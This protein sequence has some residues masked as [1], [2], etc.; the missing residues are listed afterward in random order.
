MA[1]TARSTSGSWRRLQHTDGTSDP[2]I[3]S[4]RRDGVAAVDPSATGV[5]ARRQ[6]TATATAAAATGNFIQASWTAVTNGSSDF[7]VVAQ[8]TAEDFGTSPVWVVL[9]TDPATIPSTSRSAVSVEIGDDYTVEASLATPSGTGSVG[10]VTAAD[11]RK[12]ISIAVESLQG[13]VVAPT[14]DDEGNLWK[15]STPASLAARADGS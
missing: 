2:L 14:D 3:I 5:T 7:R 6:A 15:R 9:V 11:L 10:T 1:A 13:A 12:A 4:S 8:V